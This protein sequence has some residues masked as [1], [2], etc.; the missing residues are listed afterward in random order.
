MQAMSPSDPRGIVEAWREAGLERW[1]A[2]DSLFDERMRLSFQADHF[3]AA[4]D[5]LSPWA[6]EPES[7]LALLI[8]LDQIPRNIFRGTAHMFATDALALRSARQFLSAGYDQMF[9]PDLR[10]L[11]YLPF[12]HS[13]SID[14][15]IISLARRRPLGPRIERKAAEHLDIIARFGRFPHRNAMLGRNTTVEEQ[16]YLDQGGFAG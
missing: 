16:A 8:L 3:A 15:Q 4:R 6:N 2:V 10:L 9:E 7:A 13:E 1:F 11:F 12:T 14:D 5:E